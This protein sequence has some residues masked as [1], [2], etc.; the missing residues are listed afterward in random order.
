LFKPWDRH[1]P[2]AP[3]QIGTVK[4]PEFFSTP[5]PDLLKINAYSW[6][7]FVP[8]AALSV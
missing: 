2:P 3:R 5:M 8:A 7:D 4:S 1:G 6:L